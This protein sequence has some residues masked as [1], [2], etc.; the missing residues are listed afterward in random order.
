MPLILNEEQQLLKETAREF[1]A[2]NSPVSALRKLR[3]T[4]DQTGYD[5]DT[6][7]KMV[8]LGWAGITMPEAYGGLEFGA[9]GLGAIIE[10][11]GKTLTASPLL[12]TI[13]SAANIIEL[14]GSEQ[15][16]HQ[17]LP[18]I[19]AGKV[20]LAL[21]LEESAH[22]SPE[23][24]GLSAVKTGSAYILSGKIYFVIDGNSADYF[25]VVARTS[26]KT[27][28][29]YG[30]S[31][32]IVDVKTN[33]IETKRTLLADSRNAAIV[34]FDQTIVSAEN[35]IGEIDKGWDIL[36][37]VLD[38]ARIYLAAEMLGGATECFDRTISYLKEREQFGVKIGSF[39]ALKHRAAKM[40]I[41]LEMTK[42]ALLDALTAIDEN[43]DDLAQTASLVKTMAN[44][45]YYLTT[46]E[47]VQMH[48]GIGVTDELD[49]GLFLKRSRVAIQL[50]GDS[51]YHKDRY[52]SL[53]GY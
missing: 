37:P 25:I 35:L 1:F 50:F 34:E 47:A 49:I 44:D 12:A 23:D 43:R 52:A 20:T 38:K 40:Y 4:Q 48:G 8:E 36:E 29:S 15:Q 5:K 53:C 24:I 42:S 11:S 31:L 18:D 17:F 27:N 10:E 7:Q 21:A 41:D 46:N 33:G 2:S 45:I 16:K 13:T 9:L 6:W 22:H 28:N 51:S 30:I 3:D 26:N 32:F 14:G 39:Q 19:A